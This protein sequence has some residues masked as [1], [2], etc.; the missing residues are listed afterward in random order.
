MSD[1]ELALADL[2]L[3]PEAIDA[4]PMWSH[5][6]KVEHRRYVAEPV[7]CKD[8]KHFTAH[9]EFW[10]EPPKVPFPIIGA[11][12]DSCDFWAGTKCKVTPDGYCAWG[13]RRDA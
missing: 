12:S 11:T 1:Y 3:W 4:F 8:C 7:R 6:G 9:E 10:V 2:E 13:V 5:G